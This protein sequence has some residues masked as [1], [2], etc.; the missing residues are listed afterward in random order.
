MAYSI[1]VVD[2]ED[3]IRALYK[4]ELEDEGYQVLCA[5]DGAQAL[6][7][8]DDQLVHVVVLDIKLK[9]E[10]G[11]QVLQNI[12]RKHKDT[13]VI[14]STAYG[15][16]KDDFSSWLAEAYVVKSSSLNEL[17]LQLDKIL[18]RSYGAGKPN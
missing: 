5:S 18:K 8:M 15:S 11:L 7:I 9:G 2:D 16:Y 17:K 10:S 12:V 6:D 3:S 1:L 4:A 13:P 14:L